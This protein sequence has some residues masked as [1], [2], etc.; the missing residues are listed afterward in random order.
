[1]LMMLHWLRQV[2]QVYVLLSMF[3]NIFHM[4]FNGTKSQL[5]LLKVDF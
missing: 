5:M 4:T 2:G 3:V 1:M